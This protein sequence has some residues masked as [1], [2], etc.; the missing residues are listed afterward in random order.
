MLSIP[1]ARYL[2]QRFTKYISH[3]LYPTVYLLYTIPEKF[4]AELIEYLVDT[5]RLSLCVA[6]LDWPLLK[7]GAKRKLKLFKALTFCAEALLG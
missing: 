5:P 4:S 1:R 7:P 6:E 3:N 2:V